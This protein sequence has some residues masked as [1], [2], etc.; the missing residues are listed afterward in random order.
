MREIPP[1]PSP[2]WGWTTKL[3]VGLTVVAVAGWL[4]LKFQ[5]FIGPLLMVFILAYVFYPLAKTL[6]RWLKISWRLAVTLI[7][8]VVVIV[9]LGLL[10]LG[11]LALVNQLQSLI[12]ILQN[13]LITLPK[14]LQD[15]PQQVIDF[16]PIH[17]S[18]A[19]IDL[20]SVSNQVLSSVQPLLGQV[21]NLLGI[22]ATSAASVLGWLVFI[23]LVSYFILA[24]SEGMAAGVFAI[25]IP[26]YD[27]DVKRMITELSA[28]WNAFLRGQLILITLTFI[29]YSILL[30]GFGLPFYFGLAAI[31][32]LGRFIPYIGPLIMWITYGLVAYFEGSP[33]LGL[34]PLIFAIIVVG[35]AMILDSIFDNIVSP[36]IMA[37]ALKIHPAAVLVA[38]LIG[39]GVVGL[40]GI[41]LAAPVLA[42]VKLIFTYIYRK[43]LDLDPWEGIEI[44]QPPPSVPIFTRLNPVWEWIAEKAKAYW[45]VFTAWLRRIVNTGRT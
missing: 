34:N 37:Q 23:L 35:S 24:E 13:V 17:I 2:H 33:P 15:L 39:A 9:I 12:N 26:G 28:I 16:G 31:A 45:P 25:H 14:F 19:Q 10:S 20:N 7:Y 22:I 36:R 8:A 5:N 44:R 6:T 21:G 43:M 41:L 18:L 40:I 42:T 29:A 3:I 32:S 4:V 11:G 30:G 38:A 1:G 27:A